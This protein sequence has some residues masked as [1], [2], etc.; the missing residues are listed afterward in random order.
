MS[1]IERHVDV[2]TDTDKRTHMDRQT[3]I[4]THTYLDRQTNEEDKKRE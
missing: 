2:H 1:R 4:K 3:D